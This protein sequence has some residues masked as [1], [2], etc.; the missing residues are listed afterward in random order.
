MF[1]V[2]GDWLNSFASDHAVLSGS[3]WIL[4]LSRPKLR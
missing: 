4:E 1:K 3:M 2:I